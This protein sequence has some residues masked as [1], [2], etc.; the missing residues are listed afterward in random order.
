MPAVS[1]PE[2][3]EGRQASGEG[4]IIGALKTFLRNAR[5][6]GSGK[7]KGARNSD[8]ARTEKLACA[9]FHVFSRVDECS[10]IFEAV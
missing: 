2:E 1:E 3:N 8:Y 5:N 10:Q 4:H 7:I 6:C 9:I